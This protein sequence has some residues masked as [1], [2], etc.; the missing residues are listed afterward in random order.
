MPLSISIKWSGCRKAI[1]V[2]SEE[3]PEEA[4]GFYSDEECAKADADELNLHPEQSQLWFAEIS[5]R[6]N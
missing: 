2:S 4:I 6:P 1:D 5:G 3:W